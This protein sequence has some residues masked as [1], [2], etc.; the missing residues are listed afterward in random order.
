MSS[1]RWVG[2]YFVVT[3]ALFLFFEGT[4]SFAQQLPPEVARWGYADTLFVNGKVVSMDDKSTST[5]V[6]SIY[7]AIAF[8]DDRGAARKRGSTRSSRTTNSQ[9]IRK[10]I[11]EQKP[12]RKPRFCDKNEPSETRSTKSVEPVPLRF[13]SLP[14]TARDRLTELRPNFQLEKGGGV[15]PD[16]F[17]LTLRRSSNEGGVGPH[18]WTRTNPRLEGFPS[19]D[20]L[21]DTRLNRNFDLTPKL[22]REYRCQRRSWKR[23]PGPLLGRR[24]PES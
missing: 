9:A 6:G 18:S 22:Q 13:Q 4:A 14:F 15:S 11:T 17:W 20:L 24:R 1:D 21:S 3:L 10:N 5:Q 16:V 7:Q 19:T 2:G 12:I 8:K 23:R